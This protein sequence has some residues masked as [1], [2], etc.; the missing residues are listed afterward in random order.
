[1]LF[2]LLSFSIGYYSMRCH[3]EELVLSV[4]EGESKGL[5]PTVFALW[6][7][8]FFFLAKTQSKTPHCLVIKNNQLIYTIPQLP[9]SLLAY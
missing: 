6:R 7:E 5:K 1:M 2:I 4:A 9:N 8:L 3:P